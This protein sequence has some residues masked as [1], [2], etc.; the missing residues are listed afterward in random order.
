MAPE[1]DPKKAIDS[2]SYLSP[3]QDGLLF[4]AV[5]EPGADPYF[6]QYAFAIDGALDPDRF[7]RAWQ[8]LVDRHASLRTGFAW[9]GVPRPVQVCR[10]TATLA[11]EHRDWRR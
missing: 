2:I 9:E 10:R 4:H 6:M 5:Y 8:L 1:K 7:A 3:L 11:F